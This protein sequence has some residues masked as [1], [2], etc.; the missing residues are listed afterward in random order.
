MKT[1]TRLSQLLTSVKTSGTPIQKQETLSKCTFL[2]KIDSCLLLVHPPLFKR[3]ETI[4]Q[5]QPLQMS[6]WVE[7]RKT[8]YLILSNS[9][10]LRVYR[11][12]S[13]KPAIPRRNIPLPQPA[14]TRDISPVSSSLFQYIIVVHREL[15]D[16]KKKNPNQE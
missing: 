11:E 10:S 12:V 6:T 2:H 1:S 13:E 5:L 8:G 3:C 7:S 16:F 15:S 9:I 14:L 4:N